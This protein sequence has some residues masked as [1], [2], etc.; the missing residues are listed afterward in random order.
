[1]KVKLLTP[2]ATLKGSYSVGDIYECSKDEAQRFIDKGFAESVKTT[3]KKAK[4]K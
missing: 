3:K 4:K 2:L 1:M